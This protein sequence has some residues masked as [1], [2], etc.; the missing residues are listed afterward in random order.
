MD[1]YERYI[2]FVVEDLCRKSEILTNIQCYE[3]TKMSFFLRASY[4]DDMFN[5]I[6][7]TDITLSMDDLIENTYEISEDG[8]IG[9]HIISVYGSRKEDV[10]VIWS[11][12]REKIKTKYY[13]VTL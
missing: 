6:K 13:S 8:I 7:G 12:F 4:C 5:H 9:K 2:N 11:L 1:K 3:L 10:N